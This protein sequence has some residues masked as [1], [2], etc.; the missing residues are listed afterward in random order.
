MKYQYGWAFPDADV[1]MANEIK[2][3]GSY[4]RGHLEAA[5]AHV[6]DWSCAIDGG[7]H[8]GTFSKPLAARFA[9]VIAVEPSPD[10]FEALS[11]NVAAFALANVETKRVALGA[12]PGSVRMVLDGRG[13]QMQNT[14]ARH[15]TAGG[16]IPV[17]TVDSWELPSLGLLKLDVEGSEAAALRGALQTL[18]RCKPIVIFEEKGLGRVYGDGP[19]AAA[20]V[21]VQAGYELVQSVKMDH[22]Y[23]W[24]R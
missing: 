14:G 20:R 10:T 11:A 2:P 5:L 19:G 24:R 6:T 18:K 4:Q 16:D 9:R 23:R 17:E 22:I 13:A 8:V 3:D 12:S 1:F 15:V 7:A 21:L